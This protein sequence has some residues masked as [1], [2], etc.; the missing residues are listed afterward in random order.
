MN[1]LHRGHLFDEDACCVDCGFDG[2]EWRSLLQYT[3]GMKA[4]LCTKI[5]R[6]RNMWLEWATD[7]EEGY[8]EEES[9]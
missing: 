3:A 5:G 9:C 2:A 7:W 1:E 4:P 6:K 8:W